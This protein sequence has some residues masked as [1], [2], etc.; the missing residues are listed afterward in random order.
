M[1]DQYVIIDGIKWHVQYS[2]EEYT[3]PL[4]PKH[5][6]SLSLILNN[7]HACWLKCQECEKNY[8][9]PREFNVQKH[10]II[11]KLNSKEFKKMKFINLDD[12]AIPIAE[13]KADSKDNMYFVRAILTESKV[14][15]RLVVYAG[16]KGKKDK[17]QIFVEPEIRRL[18]FDQSNIHPADV[19]IALEGTFEDGTKSSITKSSKDKNTK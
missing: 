1:D 15:K 5:H 12:E 18:A 10:Y 11:D 4:C 19:F 17:T 9:L 2:S 16:E 7:P 13:D 8:T 3:K 14:G 6:L